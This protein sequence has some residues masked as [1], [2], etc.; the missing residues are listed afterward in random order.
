MATS[1]EDWGFEW[2]AVQIV[3]SVLS[4]VW[5][6]GRQGR[7]ELER[8]GGKEWG[9][10]HIALV[11]MKALVHLTATVTESTTCVEHR[12]QKQSNLVQSKV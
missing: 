8:V 4:S 6:T 1:Y 12:T 2:A 10:Q 5:R 3:S 9:N 7:S 11:L